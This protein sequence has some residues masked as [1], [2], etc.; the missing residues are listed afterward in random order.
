[1]IV[2]HVNFADDDAEQ[3]S[4]Y[5]GVR[6]VEI[7]S[8]QGLVRTEDVVESLTDQDVSMDVIMQLVADLDE[9]V[10]PRRGGHV[11]IERP[12]S[13]LHTATFDRLEIV[14]QEDHDLRGSSIDGRDHSWM[15]T[16]V[17]DTLQRRIRDA[18][19]RLDTPD[20]HSSLVA[21]AVKQYLDDLD[22]G[23]A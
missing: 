19:M 13:S 6:R 23:D 3:I 16:H 4:R 14:R 17:P 18:T 20:T 2:E 5:K 10:D 8:S 22:G 15:R 1:M 21:A 12:G 11:T 9:N 7:P